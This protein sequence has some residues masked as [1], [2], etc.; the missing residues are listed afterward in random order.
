M[1]GCLNRLHENLN[2][3]TVQQRKAASY[4]LENP[5]KVSQMYVEHLAQA[6]GTSTAT[7]QRL[8]KSIGFTGY[9]E[10]LTA[11]SYDVA[12][13]TN[14]KPAYCEIIPG[15]DPAT[16]A[17]NVVQSS[18]LAIENTLPLIDPAV[19]CQVIDLLYNA[20]RIYFYGIGGSGI[21]ATDAYSKFLRIGKPC[22]VETD[23]DR[24][25][26]TACTLKNDD[27]A[28]IFSYSGETKWILNLADTIKK[29][30]IPIVAITQLG[31]NT[32]SGKADYCLYTTASEPVKRIGPMTSRLS[33]LVILD[34]L[35]TAICTTK[36]EYVEGK[37]DE[38]QKFFE[39]KHMML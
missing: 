30:G 1:S 2:N 3:F 4:I 15:D 14:E 13:R 11:L 27:V 16:I 29:T 26:L 25:I 39:Y 23:P 22:I 36:F 5:H 38:S 20:S 24:Q 6:S 37:L 17:K 35:Y 28:V 7:I 31:Q 32:L 18:C 8:C 19:L 9:R 10:F 21:V 34:I 33:Q 12:V